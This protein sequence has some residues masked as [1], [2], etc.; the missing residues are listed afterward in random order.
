MHRTYIV[1]YVPSDNM[2]LLDLSEALDLVNHNIILQDVTDVTMKPSSDS[3]LILIQDRKMF[4]YS[5]HYQILKQY[6]VFHRDQ[7]LD[8]YFLFSYSISA[9]CLYL[10]KYRY[11]YRPTDYVALATIHM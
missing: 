2:T 10:I 8:H 6:L 9:R 7:S 11:A 3:L 4:V 1:V 5:K